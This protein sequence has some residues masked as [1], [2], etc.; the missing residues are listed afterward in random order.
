MDL[1]GNFH[2]VNFYASVGAHSSTCC[3]TYASLG[4]F[5]KGKVVST[6]VNFLGLKL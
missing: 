5:H 1:I 3:A 6:I 2:S 4:I